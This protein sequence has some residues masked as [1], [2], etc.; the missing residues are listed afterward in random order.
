MLDIIMTIDNFGKK[1][2]IK[3]STVIIKGSSS[4]LGA[5]TAELIVNHGGN[6]LIADINEKYGH[7]LAKKLGSSLYQHCD[8]SDPNDADKP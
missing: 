3:N 7:D 5:A 4:G 6:V 1:M 8:V 2:E